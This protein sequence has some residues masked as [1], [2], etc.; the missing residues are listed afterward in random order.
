MLLARS[1]SASSRLITAHSASWPGS[2]RVR[3]GWVLMS[4]ILVDLGRYDTYC[5]QPVVASGDR[6]WSARWH[7]QRA[8][9]PDR[10]AVEHAIL[11]NVAGQLRVLGGLAEALGEGHACAELVARLLWQR[12]EQ[13]R[14]EQ[15]GGDG[16]DAYPVLRQVTGGGQSH[17]DD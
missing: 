1:C 3:R 14:V 12:G 9:Q 13:R 11:D 7:P 6:L 8:V 16:V 2:R 10:L 15:A 4:S 17:A 5:L